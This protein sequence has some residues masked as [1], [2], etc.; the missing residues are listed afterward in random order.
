MIN[1][2]T[3]SFMLILLSF[4]FFNNKLFMTESKI[5]QKCFFCYRYQIYNTLFLDTVSCDNNAALLLLPFKVQRERS[6]TS[7]FLD[8][9]LFFICIFFASII[10]S[11]PL[12]AGSR[13][14][15]PP[16]CALHPALRLPCT[17]LHFM[18]GWVWRW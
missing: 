9:N 8:H 16:P 12:L 11:V 3:N 6:T 4:F 17:R 13:S 10:F 5:M 18:N 2:Q 1:T 7:T 15:P 14:L